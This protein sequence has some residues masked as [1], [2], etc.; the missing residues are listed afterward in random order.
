MEKLKSWKIISN[1]GEK[2]KDIWKKIA[3]NNKLDI[4]T[5]GISSLPNFYFKNRNNLIYKSFITQEMLKK[6]ILSTLAI[7]V[8]IDHNDSILEKYFDN[9]ND[10]FNTISQNNSDSQLI[11]LLNPIVLADF[12]K[13]NII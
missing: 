7:Y 4:V 6:N 5:Q 2:I 10:I 12:K 8:C 11:K 1:T 9:L 3:K 13:R